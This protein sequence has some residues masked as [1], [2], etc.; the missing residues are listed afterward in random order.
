MKIFIPIVF[1]FILSG[2]SKEDTN[3]FPV[4]YTFHHVDQSDERLYVVDGINLETIPVNSG[5]YG[6]ERDSFKSFIQE[7]MLVAFDLREIELLSEDSLR[8]HLFVDEE[9]IDT[10][11]SYSTVSDSI[12]IDSLQGGLLAY[13][14]AADQFVVCGVTTFAIAGPNVQNPGVIYQQFNL[15][16]CTPGYSN[17][18]YATDILVDN[19]LLS[20]D[21]IGVI[22]T[23]FI[24][25]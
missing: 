4:S 8:I 18:D 10:V 9:E 14:K 17:E 1:V 23:K 21:T 20:L 5:T 22:L 2:C 24:F 15:D 11:V 25:E 7:F 6:I 16:G 12:V 13:D 3:S 19:G